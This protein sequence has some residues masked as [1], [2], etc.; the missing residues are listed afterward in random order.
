MAG[1]VAHS[2]G[3]GGSLAR[4]N[5]LV[6]RHVYILRGSFAR[7]VELIYWPTVQMVMW[8]FL[9][10]F[11]AQQ[12][13]WVAQGAGVLIGGMLLWD[14]LVR[15][16]LGLSISF[17]EE[18]WSRN[19]GHLF[20]S[21]LRPQE[22]A[23]AIVTM[24]LIRTLLGMVPVTIL[25]MIF[26]GFSIYSLGWP[27]VGFFLVLQMFGWAVGLAISGMVMRH[28]LGMETFA[29]AA[30]FALL[31]VSG[32]YYPIAVL[33]EWLQ[34]IAWLLPPAYVF[35]GM[36]LILIERTVRWDLLAGA[37]ALS[38]VFLLI[39]AALFQYFFSLARQRGQLLQQG[40]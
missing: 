33:P 35:E 22:M 20:A 11:L 14:C 2:G 6:L 7:L 28:G 40:E 34:T 31:P 24:S 9:T 8:G 36:R 19:L 4:I 21:P 17:L 10:Q 39:G 18:M 25:A 1:G 16:Q 32:V 15:G 13:S 3:I 23:A 26:F 27:L 37:L 29:W 38:L 5:A 30:V 12:S